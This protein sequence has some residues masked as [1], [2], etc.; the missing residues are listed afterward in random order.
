[1]L[2]RK[3]G[4]N[5]CNHKY[6]YKE[7]GNATRNSIL[8]LE[9]SCSILLATYLWTD[10]IKTGTFCGAIFCLLSQCWSHPPPKNKYE[11]NMIWDFLNKIMTSHCVK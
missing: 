1:M 7:H 8:Q 9:I 6:E 11:K 10:P 4:S 3:K 5:F 2:N